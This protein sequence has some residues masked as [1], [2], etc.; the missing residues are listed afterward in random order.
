MDEPDYMVDEPKDWM[1]CPACEHLKLD[2]ITI[3]HFLPEKLSGCPICAGTGKVPIPKDK[4]VI[5]ASP[6][7]VDT[8][9]YWELWR[10]RKY[11][12]AVDCLEIIWTFAYKTRDTKPEPTGKET[13]KWV[14]VTIKSE[15]MEE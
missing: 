15:V 11:E 7:G 8:K 1:K 14:K 6:L 5:E 9:V 10:Q 12:V 13:W 4:T 2:Y 3:P